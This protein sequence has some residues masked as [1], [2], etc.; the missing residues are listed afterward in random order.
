MQIGKPMTEKEIYAVVLK[1]G[2]AYHVA[3]STMPDLHHPFPTK[4]AALL[5]ARE[6]LLEHSLDPNFV[7]DLTNAERSELTAYLK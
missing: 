4:E 2:G 1:V 6:S 7:L 5:H 3:L